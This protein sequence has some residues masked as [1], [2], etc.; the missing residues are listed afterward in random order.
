MGYFYRTPEEKTLAVIGSTGSVGIQTLDAVE[1]LNRNGFAFRIVAL[2]ADKN[3]LF[4]SQLKKYQPEGFCFNGPTSGLPGKSIAYATVEELLEALKPDYAVI[5]SS[6]GQTLAFTL[7]AI[8]TSHRVCLAN[9]E[10]IVLGGKIVMDKAKAYETEIIPVDSE[11]SAVFQL[12]V[13]T[14]RDEIKKVILTASGGALREWSA[15]QKESAR[16]DQVLKHPS[17]KMGPK[18]TVDS[19]TLVNKALEMIEAKFLFNLKPEEIDVVFCYNSYVHAIVSLTDGYHTYHAGKPDMRIPIAY[20]LTYPRR[21]SEEVVFGDE[22]AKPF[23]DSFFEPI[24]L[25]KVELER[26]PAI[27]LAKMLLDAPNSLSVAFNASNEAAVHRF[28][29]GKIA[30]SAILRIVEETVTRQSAFEIDDPAALLVFH[31]HIKLK[32]YTQIDAI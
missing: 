27:R 6:G 19:A 14:R 17:W 8:E 22:T 21:M 7:K 25:K 13:K 11:H 31:H 5:A 30:F 12:L 32:T 2:A 10:S 28:L 15:E 26:Y 24:Q 4:D 9:K 20:S 3:P 16:V 29:E 1:R 23:Y 18:I